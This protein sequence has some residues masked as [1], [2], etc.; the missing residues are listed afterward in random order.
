MNLLN[1]QQ[2]S[3]LRVCRKSHFL[4]M[5]H[6]VAQ[7]RVLQTLQGLNN[8]DRSVPSS[9]R[10]VFLLVDSFRCS[11][12]LHY[13]RPPCQRSRSSP[14]AW[15]ALCSHRDG[16]RSEMSHSFALFHYQLWGNSCLTQNRIDWVGVVLTDSNNPAKHYKENVLTDLL[17]W[18]LWLNA[19][20]VFF[21]VRVSLRVTPQ[22]NLHI[23]PQ[24]C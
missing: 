18:V 19:V 16:K 6:V 20:V 24:H 22:V 11:P 21:C 23:I 9:H 4:N 12:P 7:L 5:K 1:N 14:A 8:P 15:L 17:S 3:E 10:C 2:D 13:Q